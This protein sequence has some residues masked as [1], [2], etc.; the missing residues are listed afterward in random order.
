M[1]V[2]EQLDE[3]Q[4]QLIAER[5][6]LIAVSPTV[7]YHGNADG[8]LAEWQSGALTD[9]QKHEIIAAVLRRITIAPIGRGKWPIARMQQRVTFG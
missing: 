8:L 4:S 9:D 7:A 3:E 1:L 5:D 6:A 2:T